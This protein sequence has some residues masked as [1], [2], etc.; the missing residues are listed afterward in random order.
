MELLQLRY[1]LTVA[2]TLNISRAAQ[3]HMIPQP[4]M[5]QTIS[6]L[7]KELGMPL[8]DRYKNKLTLT[9]EGEA[10]LRAVS[11]SIEELDAVV[12][13]FNNN[14]VLQGELT[15]L[16]RQ[17]RGTLVDCI[18]KFRKKYPEVSFRIFHFQDPN[19]TNDYDLCIASTPHSEKYSDGV[20]LISEKLQLMVASDHH[21]A[22][23]EFVQFEDLKNEEFA[24]LDKN[25][26]L[27]QHTIHLCHQAGFDPK[28]SMICGDLH[29]MEKFV[30]AG[31]AIT[32]GPE[33]S[34]QGIKN[35]K[36]V[37]VPTVPE[38]T[39][40]TYV[41]WNRYKHPSL[42]RQT[43]LDFLVEYFAQKELHFTE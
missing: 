11:T 12:N 25:N 37:F 8:F 26:S 22:K 9:K 27:W 39:R 35:D 13:K 41:F 43:F 4:A 20:S 28:I 29:C 19:D 33:L 1:F 38:E 34:W 32:L 2:R 15:L 6:R 10:F 5:S 31:M 18:V 23:K 42:L 30:A 16:V 17:H 21:L 14:G 36:V 24:L 40:T 7:E 3:H